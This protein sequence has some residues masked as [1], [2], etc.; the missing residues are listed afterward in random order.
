MRSCAAPLFNAPSHSKLHSPPVPDHRAAL[1]NFRK[2][3]RRIVNED[4]SD[5]QYGI[6]IDYNYPVLNFKGKKR[7]VLSTV[8]WQGALSSFW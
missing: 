4:L 5:G 2:L 8:S 3:Y 1:P 6:L 7:I